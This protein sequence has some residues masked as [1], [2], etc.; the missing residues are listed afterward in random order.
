MNHIFKIVEGDRQAN[1]KTYSD[2]SLPIA[3]EL[4]K[5]ITDF[6]LKDQPK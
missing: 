2:P 5:S 3:N 6:I 1:I 4:I